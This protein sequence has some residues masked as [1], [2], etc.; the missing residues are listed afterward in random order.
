MLV[1]ASLVGC[2]SGDEQPVPAASGIGPRP[3]PGR[4][5]VATLGTDQRGA[6]LELVYDAAG[7][8]RIARRLA[9]TTG[10]AGGL[11]ADGATLLFR[12]ESGPIWHDVATNTGRP[13]EVRV[14]GA[15]VQVT[16]EC[17]RFAPNGR[18]FLVKDTAGR[19]LAVD[20]G[21]GVEGGVEGTAVVVDAPG[22]ASSASTVDCGRW[23]DD[24]RIVFDHV[25]TTLAV[26]TGT[27]VRLV[28]SVTPW[29]VVGACGSWTLTRRGG[30]T[31]TPDTYL[32]NG[33]PEEALA[34]DGGVTPAARRI[35]PGA[36]MGAQA[37]ATF[38]PSCDVFVVARAKESADR[39]AYRRVN[40]ATGAAVDGPTTLRAAEGV[41]RLD[42]DGFAW[43]PG[44]EPATYAEISDRYDA[45]L[46]LTDIGTGEAAA[47]AVPEP[48]RVIAILGWLS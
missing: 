39:L 2:R 35:G 16:N 26:L 9:T 25:N 45:R 12:A 7:G 4:L 47:I 32:W 40:P 19:L 33:V 5:I 41:P 30:T 42:P 43:S 18:R 11:S 1:A 14:A 22:R 15:A 38:L 36:A 29:R 8:A 20:A 24:Q 21:D 27:G 13:L 44:A 37:A 48:G 28:E 31:Y 34:S 6:V 17:F 3:W 23:L 46:Y 10:G